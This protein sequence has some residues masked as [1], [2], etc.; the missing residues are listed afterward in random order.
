MERYVRNKWEKRA[1]MD[2][3]PKV[4]KKKNSFETRVKKKCVTIYIFIFP[5]AIP[6]NDQYFTTNKTNTTTTTTTTK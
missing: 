3:P 1:F 2:E 4:K 5:S 6:S